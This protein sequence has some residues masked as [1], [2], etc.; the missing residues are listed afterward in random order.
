MFEELVA[1]PIAFIVLEC[2]DAIVKTRLR[3]RALELGRFDDNDEV[4][5]MRIATFREDTL[6]VLNR[7]EHENKVIHVNSEGTR[8]EVFAS[9]A[10]VVTKAIDHDNDVRERT[11]PSIHRPEE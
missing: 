8:E 1:S 3:E 4:I 9:L 10:K 6:L 2:G 11:Q 7:Y 5:D